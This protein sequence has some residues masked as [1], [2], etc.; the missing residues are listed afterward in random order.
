VSAPTPSGAVYA[1][2]SADPGVQAAL[3]GGVYGDTPGRTTPPY[4]VFE[5]HGSVERLVDSAGTKLEDVAFRLRVFAAGRQEVEAAAA[6]VAGRVT[7]AALRA[8]LAGARVVL[9]T[10]TGYRVEELEVRDPDARRLDEVTLDYLIRL[11]RG[12]A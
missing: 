1:L 5:D 2:L 3:P 8:G 10:R 7:T 12:P 4:L 6:V 11:Q 9:A